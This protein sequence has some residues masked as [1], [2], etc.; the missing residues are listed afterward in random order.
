MKKEGLLT[1]PDFSNVEKYLQAGKRTEITDRIRAVAD[2]INGQ[3]DGILIRNILLWINQNTERLQNG[4]DTRKF[5]R[6]AD[7]ILQSGERTGCCDSST[8]FTVLARCKGIPTMQIITVNKEAGKKIEREGGVITSGHYFTA[9]YLADINGNS[10]WVLIDSDQ[11][12]QDI[13]DVRFDK[14]DLNNRNIRRGF[15]ALAYVNDYSNVEYKGM[16]IDSIDN[17]N[18]IQTEAYKNCDKSDFS[19][20]EERGR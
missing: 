19:S 11:P 7:E 14:L 3:T 9:C 4:R 16:R 20:R 13:R 12:V 10:N 1:I 2:L 15:Y 6:T 5:K 18:R 8:L 17:M